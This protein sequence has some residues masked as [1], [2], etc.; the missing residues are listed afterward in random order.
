MASLAVTNIIWLEAA[1]TALVTIGYKYY[2]FFII[3]TA[4]A[5]VVAYFWFPNTLHKPLEEVAAMFG[6][7]DLV[8]LY[9]ENI[10]TDHPLEDEKDGII[11]T[12][13]PK[14]IETV[15]E[16]AHVEGKI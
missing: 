11:P 6:D 8:V 13:S 5:S 15:Q 16:F 3:I 14:D 9:M 2:I 7:D 4:I 10:T 12:D 1:P